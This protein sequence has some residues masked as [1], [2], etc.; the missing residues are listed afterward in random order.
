MQS[1]Y[2]CRCGTNL[3]VYEGERRVKCG[4]CGETHQLPAVYWQNQKIGKQ[5]IQPKRQSLQS[6]GFSVRYQKLKYLLLGMPAFVLCLLIIAS[7]V[8]PDTQT[9]PSS[10]TTEPI[11]SSSPI[12]R[13][14]LPSNPS[15]PKPT[16]KPKPKPV[17]G[18]TDDHG[19]PFP[20]KSGYLKGYKPLRI[21]GYSSVTVDN[22]QNDSDVFVKLFTLDIKPPKAASVFFI[23]AHNSFTVEDIQ[24]GNYDVRYRNLSSK[25]L[26]RTEPF[27]LKE[28]R[29]ASGV[30]GNTQ[31]ETILEA[32]F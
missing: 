12:A 30:N 27:N 5:S 7:M 18:S 23:R 11:A 16:L 20:A 9:N 4:V 21:G 26:S 24:P 28:V 31:T 6:K 19:V 22:S 1:T 32:E 25:G 2:K 17:Q 13:K 15:K 14:K 8:E 3:I 10:P 29:T